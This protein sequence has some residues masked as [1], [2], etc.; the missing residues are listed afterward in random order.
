MHKMTED[1]EKAAFAGESQAHMRYLI[2]AAAADRQFPNVA[3]LFRAIS[4]AEQAHATNHLRALSGAGSTADNLDAAIAGETWEVDE[5]YP[6]YRAVADLQQDKAALR[7]IDWALA[8]EKVH[9]TLYKQARESVGA[10]KDVELGQVHICSACGYTGVGE[11]PDK[12]P[13]CGATK[14]H[15]QVF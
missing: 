10:G 4:F 2:F 1:N 5:M 14:D 3:R 8:A 6:S 7:A 13:L 9:A 15:F 11:V 12:C